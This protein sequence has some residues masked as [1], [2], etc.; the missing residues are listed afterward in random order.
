MAPN[1]LLTQRGSVMISTLGRPE[2]VVFIWLFSAFN[3][4]N[5]SIICS[6]FKQLPTHPSSHSDRWSIISVIV[7]EVYYLGYCCAACPP[8]PLPGSAL[9]G[10]EGLDRIVCSHVRIPALLELSFRSCES[11]PLSVRL[12]TKRALI[13]HEKS[14][15]PG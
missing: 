7:E 10:E 15:V 11:N 8:L 13:R 4:V 5:I 12:R 14:R 1:A 3:D 9:A 6:L 2:N